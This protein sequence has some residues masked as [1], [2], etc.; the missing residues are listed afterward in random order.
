MNLEPLMKSFKQFL[1]D[2]A[3][4]A[5]APMVTDVST[6]VKT[7]IQNPVNV[8]V[9]KKKKSKLTRRKLT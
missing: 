7:S 5:G 3:M 1:E 2:A 8:A 6:G 4:S 9:K